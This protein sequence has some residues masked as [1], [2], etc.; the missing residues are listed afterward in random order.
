M[1][2]PVQEAIL[3]AFGMLFHLVAT[4]PPQASP[5]TLCQCSGYWVPSPTCD[6]SE[7]SP[8]HPLWQGNPPAP[9][10]ADSSL[11]PTN[12]SPDRC[13][14]LRAWATGPLPLVSDHLDPGCHVSRGTTLQCHLSSRDPGV[15]ARLELTLKPT[16]V[17]GFLCPPGSVI[18]P[19]ESSFR[20]PASW[21]PISVLALETQ[22]QGHCKPGKGGHNTPRFLPRR[23]DGAG[24][25]EERVQPDS[26]FHNHQVYQEH[27]GLRAVS[28]LLF[29]KH[30][31]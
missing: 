2:T 17:H 23:T 16:S 31:E 4:L 12:S 19:R 29:V 10:Q 7:W 25:S 26:T 13:P 15:P 20:K 21:D 14:W 22:I 9:H 30:Q 27:L 24:L 11:S 8:G 6:I 5:G 28:Q 3:L 18:S 1:S